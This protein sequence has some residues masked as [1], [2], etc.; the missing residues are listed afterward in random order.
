MNT[1][2]LLD[3]FADLQKKPLEHSMFKSKN[4]DDILFEGWKETEANVFESKQNFYSIKVDLL[5]R[6]Y[7]MIFKGNS[8]QGAAHVVGQLVEKMTIATTAS[9]SILAHV[10]K[11]S[12]TEVEEKSPVSLEHKE[13][14]VKRKPVDEAVVVQEQPEAD[15]ALIA[16]VE[17]QKG[18]TKSLEGLEAVLQ[19]QE[20]TKQAE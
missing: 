6:R 5:K 18:E 15:A 13:I 16:A 14:E 9:N 8:V 12:A 19:I 10:S 1:K 3:E 20:N 17:N 7:K 4:K 2:K 11:A